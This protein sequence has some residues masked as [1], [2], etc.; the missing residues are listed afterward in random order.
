M[1]SVIGFYSPKPVEHIKRLYKLAYESKIRGLH[2]FGMY[3]KK[4]VKSFDFF[5][6]KEILDN[7]SEKCIFHS[8]YS[9]SGDW[10]NMANNQPILRNG[11][12][13]AS[14]SVISMKPKAEYEKDFDIQCFTDNDTEIFL[15]LMEKEKSPESFVK[16]LGAFAGIYTRNGGLYAIR[17]NKRPLHYAIEGDAIFVFSTFDIGHRAGFEKI[18]RIEPYKEFRIDSW[19]FD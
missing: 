8:R 12:V 5:T 18:E 19:T 6:E 2:A 7:L 9:T 1:C 11:E 10:K 15:A 14:N 4:L 3:G 16:R 17:N 13:I